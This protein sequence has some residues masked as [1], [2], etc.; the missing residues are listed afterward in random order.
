[1]LQRLLLRLR[2]QRRLQ[3]RL[4]LLKESSLEIE[5]YKGRL[6]FFKGCRPFFVACF[7]NKYP[8]FTINILDLR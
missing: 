3:L 2:L 4:N 6:L 8:V 1:M 7:Y 5:K